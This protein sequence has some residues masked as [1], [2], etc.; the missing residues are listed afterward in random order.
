ME[1]G[2][3]CIPAISCY[4]D[5]IRYTGDRWGHA[6]LRVT[7]YTT[8]RRKDINQ[9]T[10][11]SLCEPYF[12]KPYNFTHGASINCDGL[13]SSEVSVGRA[14][15]VNRRTIAERAETEY[16]QTLYTV[17]QA[18]AL[19]R[20]MAQPL[21]HSPEP[22]CLFVVAPPCEVWLLIT[23]FPATGGQRFGNHPTPGARIAA[24]HM[25]KYGRHRP[26]LCNWYI[27]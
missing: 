12:V 22:P 27:F 19:F 1:E 24:T 11:G 10:R 18:I 20:S 21:L 2:E 9:I 3:E 6:R 23:Y 8:T 16:Q 7:T 25:V 15:L 14:S 17:H 13:S 26:I 4:L 5:S